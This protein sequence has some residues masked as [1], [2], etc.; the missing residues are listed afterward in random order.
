MKKTSLNLPAELHRELKIA[1]VVAGREMGELLAEAV[2]AY[3]DTIGP[4]GLGMRRG[5]K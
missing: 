5:K 4:R 3:L 2:R 1:A